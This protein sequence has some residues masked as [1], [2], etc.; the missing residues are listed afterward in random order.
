MSEDK[1]KEDELLFL[2]FQQTREESLRNKLVEKNLYVVEILARKYLGKGIE[3]ED[4]YQVGALALIKAVDRFDPSKGYTFAS[5]ATP[6][7][8]GEI[9]KHFRDK[10]WAVKVPR[11]LKVLAGNIPRAKEDL[12]GEL[13]RI[14]TPKE[15]AER[16]EVSEKELLM[17]M[18]AGLAYS[19]FSINQTFEEE[20]EEGINPVFEKYLAI[21]EKGFAEMEERETIAYVLKG[22]SEI[23]RYIFK[24]RFVQGRTQAEI[25]K[26][27]NISQMSVSRAEK[28]IKKEFER[29]LGNED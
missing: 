2:E 19:T 8:L 24:K 1:K 25:A 27:L 26:E 5:F 3:Y 29:V 11:T 22:M 13:G 20:G 23:N 4:L 18:E 6:T 28:S 9:K 17:A 15:I 10:G 12:I 14:P 21:E 16:L 7:I